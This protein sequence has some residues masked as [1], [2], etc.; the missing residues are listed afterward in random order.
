M[1]PKL[2]WNCLRKPTKLCTTDSHLVFSQTNEASTQDVFARWVHHVMIKCLHLH[3]NNFQHDYLPQL[4]LACSSAISLSEVRRLVDDLDPPVPA[5]ADRRTPS[6]HATGCG[7]P[8]SAL[9]WPDW[10]VPRGQGAPEETQGY[11]WRASCTRNCSR[12][13]S[14]PKIY[15]G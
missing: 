12:P 3:I 7:A 5:L 6:A 1:H 14:V 15:I 11:S 4:I 10:G 9:E 13:I 2:S 8:A